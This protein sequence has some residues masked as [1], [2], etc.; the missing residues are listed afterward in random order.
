M[1]SHGEKRKREKG[2]ALVGRN[3]GKWRDWINHTNSDR[4]VYVGL[5]G[6]CGID[7]HPIHLPIFGPFFSLFYHPLAGVVALPL[8][9]PLPKFH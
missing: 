7:I 1:R 4:C 6:V 9:L 2:F 3:D 8:P 5:F